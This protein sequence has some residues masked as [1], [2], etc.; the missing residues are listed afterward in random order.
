LTRFIFDV[1]PLNAALCAAVPGILLAVGV[2]AVALPAL[3]A[4][5]IDPIRILRGE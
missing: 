5:R 2:A 3:R 1:A 4:A